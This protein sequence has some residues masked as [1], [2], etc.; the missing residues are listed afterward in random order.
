MPISAS[1]S[2]RHLAQRAVEGLVAD[3][4]PG[5]QHG[6]AAVGARDAAAQDAGP[7]QRQ[8]PVDQHLR[9]AVEA[10]REGA[11]SAPAGSG[12]ELVDQCAEV[13]VAG[14]AQDQRVASASENEPMPIC[15][16]PPSL[17]SV[18][19]CSAIA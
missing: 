19:A 13:G 5:V 7:L 10:H 18:A 17:I 4:E 16:V 14:V 3:E 8:E 15:S 1:S 9:A 12:A 2:R 11:S 6:L